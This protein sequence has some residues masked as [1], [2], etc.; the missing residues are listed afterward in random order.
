MRILRGHL[1]WIV[2]G[3]RVADLGRPV[4]VH[5][6]SRVNIR[7]LAE[8]RARQGQEALTLGMFPVLR[9]GIVNAFRMLTIGCFGSTFACGLPGIACNK[10]AL[11]DRSL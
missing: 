9:V 5:A 8:R 2:L 11:S 3:G 7:H 6:A 4:Q 10:I 1:G